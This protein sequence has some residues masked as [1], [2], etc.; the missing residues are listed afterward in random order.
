MVSPYARLPEADDLIPQEFTFDAFAQHEA[1]I[2][3]EFAGVIAG[4]HNQVIGFRDNHQLFLLTPYR[5]R[6][7]LLQMPDKYFNFLF[8]PLT[9]VRK[10]QR[11]K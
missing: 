1:V 8:D 10:R 5:H 3:W 9:G 6:Q 2:P 7:S 4:P 11:N